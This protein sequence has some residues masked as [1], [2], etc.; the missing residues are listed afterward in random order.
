MPH[1]RITG[2]K[3]RGKKILVP[4]VKEVRP[5]SDRARTTLFNWLMA[6][7]PAIKSLDLFAGSGILSLETLSRGAQEAHLVEKHD[8][9]IKPLQ[10]LANS[11]EHGK[12]HPYASDCLKWLS[13]QKNLAP[14]DRIFVD[15]PF[16]QPQ[17]LQQTLDSLAKHNYLSMEG[18]L[19]FERDKQAE[20]QIPEIFEP[21]REKRFG[22]VIGTLLI[23]KQ[24]EIHS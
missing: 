22:N 11:W 23:L 13:E 3:A 16:D 12:I 2:G 10:Q 6:F 18:A 24:H 14:F 15:P 4:D 19:Y 9:V 21:Y 5:S 1:L 20:I 7:T 8:K 17:L